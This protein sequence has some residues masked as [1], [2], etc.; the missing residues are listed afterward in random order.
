MFFAGHGHTVSGIRGETGFL[1]PY[2]AK[3]NDNSTL[4]RWD[5][6]TRG[7]EL[8]YAKH[9]LFSMDA[10]HGGLALSRSVRPGSLRFLTDMML[11]HARQVLTARRADEV[12]ADS[13]GP[14]PNHSVFTGHL[15]EGLRGSAAGGHDIITAK[16]FDGLCIQQSGERQEFAR[17]SALWQFRR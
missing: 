15:I 16:W 17:D 11:R 12:V 9:I 14:L 6:L 5:E 8:I 1:V 10:C 3:P 4:I 7:S 13:G 2:D